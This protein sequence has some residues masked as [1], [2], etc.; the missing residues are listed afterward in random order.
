MDGKLLTEKR[1]LEAVMFNSLK[2]WMETENKENKLFEDPDSEVLH[3][4]LASILFHIICADNLESNKEKH[5]FALIMKDEFDLSQEQI[6]SLYS[7]VKAL[8]SN[9]KSDLITIDEYL[10]ENPN[11]RMT[12]MSKLNQLIA[13]DS[14]SNDELEIFYDAMAVVFPDVAKKTSAF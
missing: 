11:I 7:F 13:I 10:K 4:A 12:L 2:H 6:I 1:I 14:V 5:K 8:K 9:L 3:I